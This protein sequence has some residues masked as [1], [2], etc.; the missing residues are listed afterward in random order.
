VGGGD[1]TKPAAWRRRRQGTV[2]PEADRPIFASELLHNEPPQKL[3]PARRRQAPQGTN[4][5]PGEAK[6]GYSYYH[7]RTEIFATRHARIHIP[8]IEQAP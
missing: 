6:S 7:Q 3:G 4:R 1:R 8:R 2:P 5:L